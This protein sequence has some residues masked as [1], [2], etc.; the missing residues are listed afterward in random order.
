MRYFTLGFLLVA[1]AL[2]IVAG[3]RGQ[4]TSTRPLELFN[5]MDRQSKVKYQKP[6][7]FFPDGHAA[8]LPVEGTVPM[9]L[10]QPLAANATAILD[11]HQ[12][13]SGDSY[14]DTGKFDNV[15][16]NGI[17]EG[18]E[19]TPAFLEMGKERYEINCKICHGALGDGQGMTTRYGFANIVPSFHEERL[20][21]MPDGE[22]YNAITHGKG[23][24]FGY[25]ANLTIQQR[26]AV[27][28]Y[29]RALQRTRTGTLADLTPAE[30]ENLRNPQGTALD[31]E[32]A[33]DPAQSAPTPP[34]A[35]APGT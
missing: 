12:Y 14:L 31:T 20:R 18:V 8:R 9:G 2:A 34:P 11:D 26:W 19:I 29:V 10:N 13:T 22:I 3:P 28:A 35:E 17:P 30:T 25:G 5:D 7:E 6:S 27:V 32:A 1:I 23:Q 16:G 4:K 21:Q 24:M 15:W 33:P